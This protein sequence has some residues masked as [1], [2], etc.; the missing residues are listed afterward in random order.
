VS[1]ELDIVSPLDPKVLAKHPNV[2][3]VVFPGLL[4]SKCFKADI[5]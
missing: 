2:R 5:D 1:A 4:I 3:V